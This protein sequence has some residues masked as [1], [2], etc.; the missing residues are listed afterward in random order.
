M[1]IERQTSDGEQNA[2][3]RKRGYRVEGLRRDCRHF[4]PEHPL[5]DG[6]LAAV[7]THRRTARTLEVQP[8]G[9]RPIESDRLQLAVLDL[10]KQRQ[11]DAIRSAEA[12]RTLRV[13]I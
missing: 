10:Q 13:F 11:S 3:R 1:Q 6:H 2:E 9:G 5:G 4:Q 12:D 8:L 7:P